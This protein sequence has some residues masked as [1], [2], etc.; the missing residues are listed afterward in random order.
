VVGSLGIYLV[1]ANAGGP[2]VQFPGQSI[3]N[4][5][6]PQSEN[7]ATPYVLTEIESLIPAGNAGRYQ[8]SSFAANYR[9]LDHLVGASEQ[10]WRDGDAERRSGFEVDHQ[11]NFS[12]LLYGEVGRLGAPKYL[13]DIDPR[14]L[15]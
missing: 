2:E 14:L 3:V 6:L 4:P 8:A 9:S 1:G 10:R 12:A 11:L 15:V 5:D 13:S 7:M